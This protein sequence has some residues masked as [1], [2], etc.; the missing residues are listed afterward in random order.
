VPESVCP[1]AVHASNVGVAEVR[2]IARR[3][4]FMGCA[5]KLV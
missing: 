1:S 5:F 3:M 2:R 4:L